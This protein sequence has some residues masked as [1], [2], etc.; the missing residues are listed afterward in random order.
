[1]LTIRIFCRRSLIIELDLEFFEQWAYAFD[2]VHFPYYLPNSRPPIVFAFALLL[3]KTLSLRNLEIRFTPSTDPARSPW[4]Q[5]PRAQLAGVSFGKSFES[6]CA[7]L[8]LPDRFCWEG[9]T[10]IHIDAMTDLGPLLRRS[11]NLASLHLDIPEGFSTRD[12]SQFLR[13]IAA[14]VPNLIDFA[15]SPFSMAIPGG[16]NLLGRI[17]AALQDV[18]SV[19]LRTRSF[20][21]SNDRTVLRQVTSPMSGNPEQVSI[22]R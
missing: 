3:S 12:C 17:G 16:E 20:C 21:H 9:L 1:V 19:D 18:Q 14:Y 15:M 22:S 10:T 2:G 7:K 5:F 4:S 6:A 13:D 11:P 8:N